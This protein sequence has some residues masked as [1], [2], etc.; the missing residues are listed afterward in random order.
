MY[1]KFISTKFFKLSKS[2]YQKKVIK[3]KVEAS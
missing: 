2:S 3:L 1:P